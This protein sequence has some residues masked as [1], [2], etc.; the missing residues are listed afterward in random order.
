MIEVKNKLVCPSDDELMRYKLE[1]LEKERFQEITEHLV[2]CDIC[3]QTILD[4]LPETE[5][6]WEE[7]K[8]SDDKVSENSNVSIED[9]IP[10]N[11][12]DEFEQMRQAAIRLEKKRKSFEEIGLEDL[13]IGQIWRPKADNIILPT[14]E[15]KEYFSEYELGS[16]NHFVVIKD[17][18]TEKV[19]D[20]NIIK[21]IPID[22]DLS[23]VAKDDIVIPADSNL[24]EKDLLLQVWNGKEMLAENLEGYFGN[25]AQEWIE[26]KK[27]EYNITLKH[28]SSAIIDLFSVFEKNIEN[29]AYEAANVIKQG[30]I[31]NPIY[32]YRTKAVAETNYLSLPVESLRNVKALEGV[33][34]KVGKVNPSLIFLEQIKSLIQMFPSPEFA[35]A[36]DESPSSW[37]EDEEIYF[38]G[39]LK[40]KRRKSVKE[41]NLLLLQ[42]EDAEFANRIVLLGKD[43]S[44]LIL[45]L[46]SG[47]N[48]IHQGYVSV[49]NFGEN[50]SPKSFYSNQLLNIKDLSNFDEDL[51]RVSIAR[52]DE[53]SELL[54]WKNLANSG[55]VDEN[56]SGVIYQAI[57]ER[58]QKKLN[59]MS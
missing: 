34:Q 25:I 6:E 32:R 10:A 8:M 2:I 35:F 5:E 17:A 21:V 48:P 3:P 15:G 22:D 56:L 54:N 11:L 41:E 23:H 31:T 51:V 58:E 24:L 27:K 4:F 50:E 49:L 19:G 43:K 26:V 39:K 57:K 55:E 46:L 7:L 13:Q 42:T 1:N 52:V 16:I 45:A 29:F 9:F 40:I 18:N 47:N 38:D 37:K 36:A 20:Y 30:Q 12:I 59:D 28:N 14:V 44:N 53:D 33:P